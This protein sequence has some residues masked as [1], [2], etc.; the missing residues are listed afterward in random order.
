MK[1]NLTLSTLSHDLDFNTR[2]ITEIIKSYRG[3]NYNN[4][5]NGLRID[6]ITKKLYEDPQFRKYKIAYLADYS[7]FS[8]GTSFTTI[9]KKETGMT[10]S[11][12]ISQLEKKEIEV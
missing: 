9:F 6:F 1:N 4:Y 8:S 11:Y 7:G 10:P 5:I 12:F 3:K 2:Y